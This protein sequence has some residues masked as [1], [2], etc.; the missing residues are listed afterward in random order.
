MIHMSSLEESIDDILRAIENHMRR[1][2][3]KML[4]EERQYALN[5]AREL[6]TSQQAITKHLGLLEEKNLIRLAGEERSSRGAP[7]K[8]YE[9]SKSFSL[10]IDFAPNIFDIREYD[11]NNVDISDLQDCFNGMDYGEILT[12]IENE[13]RNL[14]LKRVK[15]LKL[16]ERIMENFETM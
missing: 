3:L 15:L 2:I 16:K 12:Y 14:E 13:I 5:L 7:R 6:K 10:F 11:M 8:V 1:E 9:I 4:V